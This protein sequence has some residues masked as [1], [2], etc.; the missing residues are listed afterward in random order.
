[1][2]YFYLNCMIKIIKFCK[3][4]DLKIVFIG[5]VLVDMNVLLQYLLCKII[6]LQF[7]RYGINKVVYMLLFKYYI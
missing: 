5:S 3:L 4:I 2:L 6:D 7:F 1:M